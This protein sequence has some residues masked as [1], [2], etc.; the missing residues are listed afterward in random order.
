MKKSVAKENCISYCLHVIHPSTKF[1]SFHFQE[2]DKGVVIA[3]DC[4]VLIDFVEIDFSVGLLGLHSHTL[5]SHVR[6][7]PDRHSHT[8]TRALILSSHIIHRIFPRFPCRRN[9]RLGCYLKVAQVK[10]VLYCFYLK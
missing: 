10:F 5:D 8:D 1:E 6:D 4:L 7:L 9:H 2:H 3:L